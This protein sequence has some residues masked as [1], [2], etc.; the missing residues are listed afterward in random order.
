MTAIA[1]M[2]A[3]APVAV[4]VPVAVVAVMTVGTVRRCRGLLWVGDVPNLCRRSAGYNAENP[5]PD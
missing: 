1:P 2:T 5:V 4:V 3:V